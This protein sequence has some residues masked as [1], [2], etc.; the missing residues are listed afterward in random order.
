[1]HK[2]LIHTV[3]SQTHS[4]A[5]H[6]STALSNDTKCLRRVCTRLRQLNIEQHLTIMHFDSE[7]ENDFSSLAN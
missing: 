5:M 1:M 6:V 7:P 4:L 2:A 3:S